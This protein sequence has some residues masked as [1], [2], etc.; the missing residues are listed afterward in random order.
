MHA[1]SD[2]GPARARVVLGRQRGGAPQR[3]QQVGRVGGVQAGQGE[4]HR[5]RVAVQPLQQ[6]P[7]RPA[8]P[9]LPRG[10]ERGQQVPAYSAA[11]ARF[12]PPTA[13]RRTWPS[14]SS[15]A[16]LVM[17]TALRGVIPHPVQE[18]PA[19]AAQPASS[20]GGVAPAGSGISRTDS[21]LSHTSSTR[22]CASSCFTASSRCAG[23]SRAKS[24]PNTARPRPV[25]TPSR[26]KLATPG[27][28]ECQ[29]TSRGSSTP[30]VSRHHRANPFASSVF[31]VPPGPAS[32]T[33]RCSR[34]AASSW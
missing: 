31:P 17:I 23:S 30:P 26:P 3:G 18:A 32:T 25:I 20:S 34:A 11:S 12:S 33:T 6:L 14:Q 13:I 7:E 29:N 21:K 24:A 27:S 28:N 8:L 5:Q 15:C 22:Y 10:R 1:A 2:D 4:P 9:P 16:R 19:A